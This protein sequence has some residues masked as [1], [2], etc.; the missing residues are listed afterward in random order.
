MVNIQEPVKTLPLPVDEEGKRRQEDAPGPS[1]Q[2]GGGQEVGGIGNIHP[3]T[4]WGCP[5]VKEK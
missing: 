4:E 5:V 2:G 3:I 1:P